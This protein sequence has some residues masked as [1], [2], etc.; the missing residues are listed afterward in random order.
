MSNRLRIVSYLVQPQVM[1]D[2][3]ETLIP[4]NINPV[5]IAAVEWPNV[6]EHLASGIEELRQQVEGVAE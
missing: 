4:L 3:G 6:I 2:D 1:L 5:T